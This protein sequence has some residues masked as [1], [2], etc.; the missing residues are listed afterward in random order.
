[1]D[2]GSCDR[3]ALLAS[4]RKTL[5]VGVPVSTVLNISHLARSLEA[6]QLAEVLAG[7]IGLGEQ[8]A[9][10]GTVEHIQCALLDVVELLSA[11]KEELCTRDT[12]LLPKLRELIKR[13]EDLV[14]KAKGRVD[15]RVLSIFMDNAIGDNKL[16]T[17]GSV[18]SEFNKIKSKLYRAHTMTWE[19]R[20]QVIE[21]LLSNVTDKHRGDL[22]DGS[23]EARGYRNM[24]DVELNGWLTLAGEL[25]IVAGGKKMDE[26]DR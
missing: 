22:L 17:G 21:R 12:G 19:E 26:S 10:S 4:F 15:Y 11:G 9:S 20:D 23:P 7:L 25:K 1:M 13:F 5:T 2:T 14:K 8:L 3:A 24:S 6:E 18:T 16:G